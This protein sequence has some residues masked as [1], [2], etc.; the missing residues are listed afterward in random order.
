M[1]DARKGKRCLAAAKTLSFALDQGGAGQ[2]RYRSE[3]PMRLPGQA[4]RLGPTVQKQQEVGTSSTSRPQP[5]ASSGLGCSCQSW[6]FWMQWRPLRARQG[7]RETTSL[8]NGRRALLRPQSSP[9][10]DFCC[11]HLDTSTSII[12]TRCECVKRGETCNQ[13]L[14]GM[15]RAREGPASWRIPLHGCCYMQHSPH[16]VTRFTRA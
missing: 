14:S 8:M 2:T 11:R 1:H 13:V 5:G 15:R 16:Q 3:T 7:D 12:L 10:E 9:R 4:P 6:Q